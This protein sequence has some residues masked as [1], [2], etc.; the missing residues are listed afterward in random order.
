MNRSAGAPPSPRAGGEA[1]GGGPGPTLTIASRY[2]GATPVAS[3]LPDTGQ[4]SC[5]DDQRPID[6]P[7]PR[8]AFYGQDAQY[9]GAPR[10]YHDNGDGTVTDRVTGLTWQQ[11]HEDARVDFP[12][13]QAA[14]AALQLG[15][16]HDWRLP[17]ITEL[18]SLADFAGVT[19]RRAFIDPVF[20]LRAPKAASLGG[21]PFA[22]THRPD[23]M[24]Q[25]WS[26]TLYQGEHWD[27]PG[28]EAAFFFNFLDGRIK[29]APT[30]GGP[31]LFHRCVRGPAWG[32]NDFVDNGD[33]T[34][35]DR[36][37]DLMWQRADDGRAREW[38][39]A[40][41]YCEAL[42]LAGHADWRLP[43][44]KELQSLVDYR[45]AAPAID[46]SVFRISDPRAW[47]WSSTTHGEQAS[48]AV[49]VC[50]GK[51]TSVD[52]VDVHGAGAQRS[53]PKSGDASRYR[54]G[55]GGQRDE[56]RVRND[57]RCVRSVN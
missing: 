16:H 14:C 55:R 29:Q 54:N 11:A 1:M 12:A 52:G 20:E 41:A 18:F 50:F 40:L 43:N 13:A 39:Q 35:T 56:V 17:S 37:F 45:R 34:V 31:G 49:Y 57:V 19:G 5:F 25:T 38:G 8:Q 51:C 27:R 3:R 36:A 24:G 9:L 48:E 44:A 42:T 15:G 28:V 33:G 4:G 21:D 6:C 30:H 7:R 46:L 47:F 26:S 22:A 53:D 10:N 32:R 23:M 2:A